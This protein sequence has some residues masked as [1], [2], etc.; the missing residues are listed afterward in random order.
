MSIA[1]VVKPPLLY[2]GQRLDRDEFY[3]RI[4]DWEQSGKSLRRIERLE[5][6]VYM[7]AAIRTPQ[8]GI[9]HAIIMTWLGTYAAL[10]PGLDPIGPA[11][12]RIDD[13]NDPESDAILRI[14]P[15][16][17][18]QSEIDSQG[19]IDG[20]PELLVEVT[21]ST[22]ERDLQTKFEI[23][24]RNGVLEYLVWETIAE[25]FHWFVL[26]NGEYHRLLPDENQQL[27]SRVFP[28]LWLDVPAVLGGKL[29]QVLDV[30]QHGL[31][32]EEHR[33]FVAQL[34]AK[35]RAT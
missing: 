27:R 22:T 2:A 5:G 15:E 8:H 19:Y 20:A 21:A 9:P 16:F 6:V 31:A 12:L 11:T 29:A 14:R 3:R 10:T 26:E 13:D 28:G 17:G 24:R 34:A 32:T 7:S 18:G 23:Y 35:Q 4:E 33:E 1:E 30:V 25:E